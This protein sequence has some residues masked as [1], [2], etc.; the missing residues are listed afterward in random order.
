MF[1]FSDHEIDT[2]CSACAVPN[3]VGQG[4][5][6]GVLDP[7][8][9]GA[10]DDVPTGVPDL[11]TV[12]GGVTETVAVLETVFVCDGVVDGVGTRDA[13]AAGV[14]EGVSPRDAETEIVAEMLAVPDGVDDTTGAGG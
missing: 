8:G 12:R 4:V 5:V 10:G 2:T 14:L 7:V 9:V 6:E 13:D 3:D 1:G 11:D